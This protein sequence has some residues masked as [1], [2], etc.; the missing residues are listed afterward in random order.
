M[1]KVQH[2]IDWRS[3]PL[4]RIN[5]FAAK[6]PTRRT[7]YDLHKLAKEAAEPPTAYPAGPWVTLTLGQLA[8]LGE[9]RW[10]HDGASPTQVHVVKEIIDRA[11]VG[12]PEVVL[13]DNGAPRSDA[14][15]PQP[16]PRPR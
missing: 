5:W 16:W 4:S 15:V 14:Y 1:S 3:I 13:Q 6:R 10:R 12:D 8:D 9:Q 7:G 2:R 11:A